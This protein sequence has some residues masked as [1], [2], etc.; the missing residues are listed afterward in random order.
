MS[1]TITL[2]GFHGTSSINADAILKMGFKSSLGDEEWLGDGVYFFTE[3]ISPPQNN[4]VKWAIAQ[5]WDNVRRRHTHNDYSV[6]KADI[7]V[8]RDNFLDLT[9]VEGIEFFNY[10]RNKYVE[11]VK[12]GKVKPKNLDFKDGHIINDAREFLN[13]KIDVTK[14]NFYIKFSVERIYN[15]NFRTP[16][17]TILAVFDVNIINSNLSITKK[18]L[19]Q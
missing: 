15:I 13:V 17:T 3:G 19:V 14:G 1:N 12:K 8:E 10:L 18:G 16:N 2:E 5:S 4:A 6:I 7:T 11:S 9:S